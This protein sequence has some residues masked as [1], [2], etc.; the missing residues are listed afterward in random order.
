MYMECFVLTD[1]L[2]TER[3]CIFVALRSMIFFFSFC[4]RS[5]SG[6]IFNDFFLII[7]QIHLLLRLPGLC[8]LAIIAH[9][10][11]VSKGR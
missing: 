10:Y 7:Y 2:E 5:V 1:A 8:F 3:V 9:I 6:L 4:C 11:V